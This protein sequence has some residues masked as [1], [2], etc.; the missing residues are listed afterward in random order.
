MYEWHDV[1][2]PGEISVHI[3]LSEQIATVKRAAQEVGWC[4]VA[5]GIE[6]RGTRPGTYRVSE[7]LVDK[8]SNK[9]GWIE[10]ELGEMVNDDATPGTPR[11]S[12]ERYMPA[13]S[14]TMLRLKMWP[15]TLP[16]PAGFGTIWLSVWPAG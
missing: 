14:A 11:K 7:M 15:A 6:G 4:F 13:P 10:N 5:T 16:A 1:G 12:G 3:D 9:Y 8:H 2:G